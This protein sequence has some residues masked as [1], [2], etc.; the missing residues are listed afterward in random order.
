M[1]HD[2]NT[3]KNFIENIARDRTDVR[4]IIYA[5]AVEELEDLRV[6]FHFIPLPGKFDMYYILENT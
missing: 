6:L 2:L 5:N 1:V 4:V 3:D